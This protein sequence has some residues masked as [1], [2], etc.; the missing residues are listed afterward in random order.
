MEDTWLYIGL[1]LAAFG[2]ITGLVIIV[3]SI[4]RLR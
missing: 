2:G 3:R 4:R 1:S